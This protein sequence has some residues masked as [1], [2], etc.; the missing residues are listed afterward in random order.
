MTDPATP[1]AAMSIML[2]RRA[3]REPDRVFLRFGDR[4]WTYAAAAR[5]AAALA[6]AL[7]RLGVRPGDRVA[8][9]LHNAPEFVFCA[10]A[11]SW[12]G[13]VEVPVNTALKGDVLR[14]QI[15]DCGARLLVVHAPLLARLLPV[16]DGL[17]PVTVVV[18]D[19]A[20]E[21]L[22]A[23]CERFEALDTPAMPD[24]VVADAATL[25]AIM[26]TSGTT[27]RA[28]GVEVTHGHAHRF[29]EDWI[30][31]VGYTR[32]D[33]LLTPLPLFHSIAR[34]LGVLPTLMAGSQ[35]C[36]VERF[37][38]SRFWDQARAVDATI[39]HGIFGM[40]PILLNQPPRAD[41]R[42]HRVRRFYIG[43]SALSAAFLE[44][45]GCE[46]IEVYGAT[47]TGVVTLFE[48][49]EE[50]R[51]GSC[52][53]ANARTYDVDVVD[54]LD[55]PVPDGTVGEIVVRSRDPWTLLT[56][57]HGRPE[58]TAEAFRNLWFHTGDYGRR[59][60]DGSFTFVDRKKDAIRRRGEN[61]TSAE[62]ESVVNAHPAVQ[63]S[64]VIAVP[65]DLGEDDVKACVVLGP[66]AELDM[67]EL[68]AFLDERLPYFMVPR[69]IEILPELPKTAN[70]K[71][72]KVQLRQM[73]ERGITAQT[74]DREAHGITVTR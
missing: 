30:R 65:S 47:E 56:G 70:E 39:V 15:T 49:G 44:R 22:P 10:L 34:T 48:P 26:Y 31:A 67:A 35:L 60:T 73:G 59:D 33:V 11:V 17:E 74:W 8:L 16:L 19:A 72:Q 41:D 23:G 25:S 43:P 63:E 58:E 7:S 54:D 9:M 5:E 61:I 28:K 6:G 40:V 62:V 50:V 36:V 18:V 32:D 20:D 55:H 51:A 52:G 46:V 1:P 69:Y 68:I 57:Y 27:G 38:A 64:A 71:V 3:L 24:P 45:F 21:E 4:S 13:A 2:H 42:D 12:A 29:A 37:S 14:H 53:R 66:G